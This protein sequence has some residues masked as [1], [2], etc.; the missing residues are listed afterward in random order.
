M[1]L[2]LKVHIGGDVLT[3]GE[4]GT[5]ELARILLAAAAMAEEG[6]LSRLGGSVELED[7]NGHAV[8]TAKLVPSKW[9]EGDVVW[10]EGRE[11]AIEAVEDSYLSGF[12]NLALRTQTMGVRQTATMVD[13]DGRLPD[14]RPLI[15]RVRR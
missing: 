2:V 14:G 11:C 6:L 12:Q 1:D 5:G 8:G 15:A 10:C 13:P 4:T 3:E 9:A 7:F